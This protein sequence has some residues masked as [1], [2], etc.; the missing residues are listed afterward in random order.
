MI[1]LGLLNSCGDT[2]FPMIYSLSLGSTLTYISVW[3]GVDWL[4]LVS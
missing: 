1:G 3:D 2:V 4:S